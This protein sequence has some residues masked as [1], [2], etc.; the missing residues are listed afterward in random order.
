MGNPKFDAIRDRFSSYIAAGGH[1]SNLGVM[2]AI[3]AAEE[4]CEDHRN[5][6]DQLHEDVGSGMY[7]GNTVSFIYDKM[8]AY[9]NSV[10]RARDAGIVIGRDQREPELD[11]LRAR[12]AELE[13]N[14]CRNY[15]CEH[16]R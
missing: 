3:D 12:V 2:A 10:G 5:L 9:K 8:L 13:A 15:C 11:E 7:R 14:R 16:L 4:S 6:Q 1:D